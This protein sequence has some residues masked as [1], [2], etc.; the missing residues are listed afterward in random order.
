V[1][2][3]HFMFKFAVENSSLLSAQAR[4]SALPGSSSGLLG[5]G[6][7][8]SGGGS[9]GS[10]RPASL[11]VLRLARS[12][13]LRK[14]KLHGSEPGSRGLAAAGA[15]ARLAPGLGDA[16]AAAAAVGSSAAGC[17]AHG[18]GRGVL[19]GPDAALQLA[20]MIS[21]NA[22][23]G[24]A[25]AAAAALTAEAAE[26]VAEEDDDAV[27]SR[28][29]LR[30]VGCQGLT[31]PWVHGVCNPFCRIVLDA[32]VGAESHGQRSPRRWADEKGVFKIGFLSF[33]L[34]MC[35]LPLNKAPGEPKPQRYTLY[36]GFVVVSPRCF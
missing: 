24:S 32:K 31:N 20:A 30:V 5:S 17:A 14:H 28:L 34:C 21:A 7:G 33:C 18:K 10:A 3:W 35:F 13:E 22:H 9:G 23:A 26:L 36:I 29:L 25:A 12:Q 4:A 8:G 1:D 6:G 19:D 16:A 11:K 15:L 27:D 2:D